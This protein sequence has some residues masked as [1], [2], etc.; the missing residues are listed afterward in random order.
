VDVEGLLVAAGGL[1]VATPELGE[2]PEACRRAKTRSADLFGNS[3]SGLDEARGAL[4]RVIS[5]LRYRLEL[6]DVMAIAGPD[7]FV[8]NA[9]GASVTE[10]NTSSGRS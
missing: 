10:V 3:L 8:G 6:P 2:V 9:L 5:G 1:V 7:L 4:G